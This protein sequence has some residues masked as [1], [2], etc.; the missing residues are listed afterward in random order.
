VT[1]HH[2]QGPV[3]SAGTLAPAQPLE[4]RVKAAVTLAQLAELTIEGCTEFPPGVTAA[5]VWACCPHITGDGE[6]ER[7]WT[8][9]LGAV[10]REKALDEG[11]A[12]REIARQDAADALALLTGRAA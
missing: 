10:E 12:A 7:L 11:G 8:A 5:I 9:Y 2:D 6:R 3:M 1:G 4:W